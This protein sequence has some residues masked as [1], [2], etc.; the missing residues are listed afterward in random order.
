MRVGGERQAAPNAVIQ[1]A[2][3]ISLSLSPSIHGCVYILLIVCVLSRD[4]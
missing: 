4:A 2:V 1:E 3:I